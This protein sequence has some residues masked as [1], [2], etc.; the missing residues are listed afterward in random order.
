MEESLRKKFDKHRS[1][2]GKAFRSVCYAPFVSLNFTF[3]GDVR[4]CC[5][6]V[7]HKLGNI[8]NNTI[9]EM[10]SGAQISVLRD[11]LKR[12]EF[13]PGCDLCYFR[14]TSGVFDNLHIKNYE[15]LDVPSE[16]PA[17]PRKMEFEISNTC[18]LECVMCTGRFS[19]TIRARREKLPPLPRIYSDEIL[20]SFR[21]YLPHLETMDF[22]G[23]EPFLI[24]EYDRIWQMLIEDDLHPV[25]HVVTNATQWNRRVERILEQLPMSIGVS[26]DGITAE[27]YEGIRINAK[28]N[29]VFENAKRFRAYARKKK[30]P[31][32]LGFCL[33]RQNWHEFGSFCLMA[34]EWDCLAYVNTVSQP[35]QFGVYNMATDELR[36][37]LASMEQEAPLL[38]RNLRRNKAVWLGELNRIR[39]K[40]RDGDHSVSKGME[41]PAPQLRLAI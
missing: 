14:S 24:T 41:R 21:K 8:L 26:L 15:G 19:S 12:Y 23:G 13:G 40:C 27:T 6:N 29:E 16:T 17:W 28:F 1:F 36:K 3:N 35:P 39:E 31:F 34:D 22:L 33:M 25:C 11:A 20:N 38:E 7:K 18:N 2:E 10:W 30:S 9:D 32:M 4:V 37:V 5:Y